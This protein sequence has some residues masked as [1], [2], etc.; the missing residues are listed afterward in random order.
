MPQICMR[1]DFRA[2]EFGPASQR[3]IYAAALDQYVW[4]DR[5]GFDLLVLSEHHGVDDG[6]QPAPLTVAAAVLGMTERARVMISV[7]VLPLHDPIRVAEQIAV[8]D[9]IAPGRLWVVFGVGY[10]VPEFEMAGME[11]AAVVASSRSTSRSS[12][13]RGPA[14]SSSGG[15]GTSWSRR[16]RPPSPTRWCSWAAG[17]PPPPAGRPGCGSRCSR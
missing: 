15:A 11:H 1:Q 9:N 14:R 16:S 4:A 13:R 7:V 5:N 17:C 6:W 2:P 12:R 10:R 3:E 8:L